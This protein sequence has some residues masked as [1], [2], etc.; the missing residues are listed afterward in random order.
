MPLYNQWRGHFLLPGPLSVII[1]VNSHPNRIRVS[2][3]AHE[4]LR[5]CI[6]RATRAV[7]AEA[8]ALK[9][10]WGDQGTASCSYGFV[11]I[12]A[13]SQGTPLRVSSSEIM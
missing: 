4:A 6:S 9:T 13:C 5:E 3:P 11:C 1:G 7:Q 12:L 2:T 8:K 10:L